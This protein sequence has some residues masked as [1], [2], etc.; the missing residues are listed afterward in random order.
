M[1][2]GDK[3]EKTVR[4]A[5]PRAA[6]SSSRLGSSCN[7]QVTELAEQRTAISEVLRA[8]ANVAP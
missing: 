8:I 7:G 5:K 6:H 2:R 4:E 3:K 1:K